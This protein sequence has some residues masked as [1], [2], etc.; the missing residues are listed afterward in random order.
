MWFKRKAKNLR[1]GRGHV[2]EVKL[3][4]REV[5][6][7][8]LRLARTAASL[9]LGAALGLFL[10]WRGG[11]WALDQF[12][13]RNEAFAIRTIDIRT[14]GSISLERLR[15]WAGVKPGDNLL[16]LDL[17]RVKRDLELAPTIESAAVER[18]L[19]HTLRIRVAERDPIAQ[20]KVPQIL[21]GGGVKLV[22]YFLD[23][24]GHVIAP[25]DNEPPL[26]TGQVRETVPSL[27]GVN[28]A[29]LRPGHAIAAPKVNA[30]LRLISAFEDSPMSGLVDVLTVDLSGTDVLQVTT[31]QGSQITFA[32]DRVD[33]QIRRWRAV[34][35]F[36][37]KLGRAIRTLDLSVTNNC[38]VLWVDASTLPPANPKAAKPPR[39]RKKHV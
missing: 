2:L 19:P 30:A 7:A 34:H 26:A 22:S 12:V 28:V 31:G 25:V 21:T 37:M 29:D 4:T 14:D 36:G 8:R 6:A 17:A 24:T 23:D 15:R 1:L 33:E 32:T 3:R 11:T 38:P 5:R 10:V 27:S 35:D 13:C 16:A 9:A 39:N 18:V 20:V